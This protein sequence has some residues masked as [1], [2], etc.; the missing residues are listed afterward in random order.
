MTRRGVQSHLGVLLGYTA[1]ALA[2]SWPL[3]LHLSTALTGTPDGD[4]GVYVWNQWVFQHEIL[5]H[6]NLPYFTDAIFSPGQAANLSL[7]N[8]T[9]FQDLLALPL[10]PLFG[11]VATFNLVFLLMSVLTAYSTFL[12]ARHVTGRRAEAW[13]AGLLFAWSPLLVTRGM[14]HFS[15]VAAAPLAIFLL[16]LMK[17]DGHERFR[18]AVALGAV[19]AWAATTDVYY[20]VYCLLIGAVFLAARVLAIHS[21][22]RSGRATAV[23]WALDVLLLSTAGLVAAIVLT[24][25][26]TLNVMGLTVSGH[27]LYTPMLSLTVLAVAR[28]AWRMRASLKPTASVDAWRLAYLTVSACL[29]ATAL[30]SPVLYAVGVRFASGSF[31]STETYWRSSPG[32]VDLLALVTPNPNHPL[33]TPRIADWLMSLKGGYLESVV[34]IPIVV[35]LTMFVAWRMGWRASPW[36]A[37][38]ALAFGALALG[39]FIHVAGVNTYVPGPWALLRYVPILGLARTPTRFSVVMM[40]AAAVLFATALEWIGRRHPERRWLVLAVVAVLLLAEL[41]PAPMTLHSAE[42]PRFYQEVAAAPGDVRVLE[43]PTGVSD[44]TASV[45]NFSARYQFFQTAHGKPLIGGYLSRVSRDRVSTLRRIEMIDALFVL[46]E[47]GTLSASREAA[48]IAGGPVFVR[49]A[50]LGFVVVDRRRASQALVD[51]AARAFRLEE[52]AVDGSLVLYRP[53][54]EAD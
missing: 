30:L 14:G 8:Y 40:L 36:W 12:L 34:S 44:G 41:L 23:R 10:T 35:V 25:G 27:S 19:V 16:V 38:L 26:R 11:V 22:P 53:R 18:D 39:P 48:L 6:G 21:G 5:V 3:P 37:A 7:H 47:G 50:N 51:F 2:F 29:V 54:R 42:V 17:A 32:G 43:L 20:G 1:T 52:V 24:G 9:A 46:S 45:G 31:P 33:A 28:V 49:D 15:L 4:T 13:L